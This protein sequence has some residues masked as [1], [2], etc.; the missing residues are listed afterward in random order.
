MSEPQQLN[1]KYKIKNFDNEGLSIGLEFDESMIISTNPEPEY[2]VVEM[3]DFR[4]PDGKLIVAEHQMRKPIPTQLDPGTAEAIEI[5]GATAGAGM[6]ASFSFNVVL[7]LLV[8][9]S[10]NQMLSSIKN[11]QVIVHLTLVNVIIPAN[12]TIFFSMIFQIIAFDPIDIEEYVVDFFELDGDAEPND[13]SPNF[14]QLG[15]ESSFFMI[16]M[17]S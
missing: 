7:N 8:S 11:L 15:Y 17:G 16:N 14:E 2:L 12:A 1:F 10:L 5:V 13:I 3:K 6:G 4:D 9:Q